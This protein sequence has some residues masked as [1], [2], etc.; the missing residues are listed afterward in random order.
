MENSISSVFGIGEVDA[1]SY[2]P[3]VLAYIGDCV[4]ELTIRTLLVNKGNAPVNTLNKKAS[5]LA[6]APTQALMITSIMD[7]LSEEEVA[8]YKRGRNAKSFT[9]AKNSSLGDYRKATG[10]E[11]LIGYLYLKKETQRAMEIIRMGFEAIGF[12]NDKND[13]KQ[14]TGEV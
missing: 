1:D 4:Y 11:A 13:K 9:S 2:S 5:N 3:L 7:D 6:K 14:G 10:F 8:V 12:L